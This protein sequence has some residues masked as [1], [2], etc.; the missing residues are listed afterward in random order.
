[1]QKGRTAYPW[2]QPGTDTTFLW[3]IFSCFD[4]RATFVFDD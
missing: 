4:R 3:P 1:V 2:I